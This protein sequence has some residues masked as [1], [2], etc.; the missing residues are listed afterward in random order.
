MKVQ[1]KTKTFIKFVN[2]RPFQKNDMAVETRDPAEIMALPDECEFYFYDSYVGVVEGIEYPFGPEM[3][4]SKHYFKANNH[5]PNPDHFR[6][7]FMR[8][9]GW[10]EESIWDSADHLFQLSTFPEYT[11]DNY[12]QGVL[13][14][15]GLITNPGK[16]GI[17]LTAEKTINEYI[18]PSAEERAMY[19]R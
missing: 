19:G 10:S 12:P 13:I 7:Y 6:V 4:V 2:S 5:Y 14:V 8:C 15:G 11:L 9:H 1:V 17:I 16:D 18:Y 3:N